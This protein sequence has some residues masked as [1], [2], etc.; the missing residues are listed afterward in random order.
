MN[1]PEGDVISLSDPVSTP[2][3]PR[4]SESSNVR[5][6]RSGK[7]YESPRVLHEHD[8]NPARS[9][10]DIESS[11]VLK[12][13]NHR[14]PLHSLYE[15]LLEEVP[16]QAYMQLFSPVQKKRTSKPASLPERK[17]KPST[18]SDPKSR[19]VAEAVDH[20]SAISAPLLWEEKNEDHQSKANSGGA[21]A[22]EH[23]GFRAFQ[24]DSLKETIPRDE[25]V[26]SNNASTFKEVSS[27]PGAQVKVQDTAEDG[28]ILSEIRSIRAKFSGAAKVALFQPSRVKSTP[29]SKAVSSTHEAS[30][31]KRSLSV[32]TKKASPVEVSDA[33]V[34][35]ANDLQQP[36]ST[37]EDGTGTLERNPGQLV[38]IE[39]SAPTPPTVVTEARELE[40]PAQ[41]T[42]VDDEDFGDI[43]LAQTNSLRTSRI[44][45]RKRAQANAGDTSMFDVTTLS[46]TEADVSRASTTRSNKS[47]KTV[48]WS[49]EPSMAIDAPHSSVPPAESA[50][51]LSGTDYGD[52][53]PPIPR[54]SSTP[55]PR[56]SI[57]T[58][59]SK[60][61]PSDS[62]GVD[63]NQSLP[64]VIKSAMG[65][66]HTLVRTLQDDMHRRFEQQS[67]ELHGLRLEV[68]GLRGE[69]EKLRSMLERE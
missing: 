45:K 11:A 38:P 12:R 42:P 61:T 30:G 32:P 17:A 48:S 56:T 23:G 5:R 62:T 34:E 24:A 19:A 46:S 31:A 27:V 20:R 9:S 49:N 3:T 1:L 68:E 15:P 67:Q 65:K 28:R 8:P 29:A 25:N 36:M 47:R 40:L 14:G 54:I 22:T 35:R 4:R 63:S 52:V 13:R 53:F 69:N 2:N 66:I 58:M 55:A 60:Q 51:R 26:K 16:D 50:M 39:S 44:R 59:E 64:E 18:P 21:R 33:A 6:L 41:E 7:M 57:S 10:G 43:W 37:P